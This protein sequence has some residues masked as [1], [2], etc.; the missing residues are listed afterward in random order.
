MFRD[1]DEVLKRLQAQLLEEQDDTITLPH[2]EEDSDETLVFAP[3]QNP[4][5][6][7]IRNTDKTDTDLSAYSEQVEKG[8]RGLTGLVF[9]ALL[10]SGA[11]VAILL[12]WVLRYF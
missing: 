8:S 4:D 9:T 7:R 12:Y 6:R 2:F 11:I 10:L 3:I 1:K 5:T